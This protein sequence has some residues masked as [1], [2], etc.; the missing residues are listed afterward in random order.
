M[1]ISYFTFQV[2]TCI[3]NVVDSWYQYHESHLYVGMS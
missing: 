1:L 2:N 3:V